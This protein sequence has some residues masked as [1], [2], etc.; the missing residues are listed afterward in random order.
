M[1]CAGRM[2]KKMETPIMPIM[3]NQMEKK[4]EKKMEIEMETGRMW[5]K[6]IAAKT[7]IQVLPCW[8]TI[9]DY[10]AFI[11]SAWL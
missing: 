6:M 1:G 11:F 10:D 3:E 2:E 8:D 7:G 9:G 4:M 5:L